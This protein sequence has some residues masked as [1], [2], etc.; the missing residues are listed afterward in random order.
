M[1]PLDN[2]RTTDSLT[3]KTSINQ[4]KT[5]E[6]YLLLKEE[7]SS[8]RISPA[9]PCSYSTSSQ[10][11]LQSCG[12]DENLR[13]GVKE[14]DICDNISKAEDTTIPFESSEKILAIQMGEEANTN[15]LEKI[16]GNEEVVV[17]EDV[18]IE[19]VARGDVDGVDVDKD[20]DVD[21]VNVVTSDAGDVAEGVA[22]DDVTKGNADDYVAEGDASDDVIKGNADVDVAEGDASDDITKGNADVDAAKGDSGDDIAEGGIGD[23]VANSDA[24]DNVTE[25]DVGVNVSKGNSG[26]DVAESGDGDDVAK[27]DAA[28]NS[29]ESDVVNDVDD[30]NVRVAFDNYV[31]DDGKC[32]VFE[33]NASSDGNCSCKETSFSG[34][35]PLKKLGTVTS[36][37]YEEDSTNHEVSEA[38]SAIAA[39]VTAAA[40]AVAERAAEAVAAA[41]EAIAAASG[42]E[43]EAHTSDTGTYELAVNSEHNVDEGNFSTEKPLSKA[44]ST[45]PEVVKT[46]QDA[47]T[48][49]NSSAAER[50]DGD[51]ISRTKPDES[52]TSLVTSSN[53]TTQESSSSIYDTPLSSETSLSTYESWTD[54]SVSQAGMLSV[55]T[56]SGCPVAGSSTAKTSK[57]VKKSTSG[58]SLSSLGSCF[59]ITCV[60][61]ASPTF[62]VARGNS[63][64][65]GT[66]KSR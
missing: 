23:D 9:E 59:P 20:V 25:R 64:Y 52:T 19:N 1:K 34:D 28:D 43:I 29:L 3:E 21:D 39:A 36:S 54:I 55:N 35:I 8:L 58:K 40:E 45:D 48:I 24:S 17:T 31:R 60:G 62:S 47:V 32:E 51:D 2:E 13:K 18:A 46:K 56:A 41:A 38:V 49:E 26:D 5:E 4:E 65:G 27:G 37:D 33:G 16:L 22:S 7:C 30:V 14:T 11:S 63:S 42:P 53:S 6:N 12:N 44:M 66:V 50:G 15:K 10:E 61:N 57:K